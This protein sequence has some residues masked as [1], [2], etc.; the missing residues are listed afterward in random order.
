MANIDNAANTYLDSLARHRALFD[1]MEQYQPQVS[2]LLSA[3][4]QTLAAGGKVIWFGNG[5]SAADAQHL[6]AEFVVRYKKERGPLASI[7]LTTDTSILTAHSNDYHFDTVFERQVQ[8]LCKPQDLVIG[9]TT[10]GTSAN[11]NLALQAAND[12]GAYTV[13]LTGR[14]GGT[15]KD[16]AKLPIII[17]ND[18][19]ARIQE[20]HM[21]IGHWLCEALDMLV[22][23]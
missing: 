8:A 12:I 11:I 21:F 16:I 5:G 18:E 19:T 9:L 2:Q 17:S 1:T 4:H 6:A 3:C 22:A 23:E 13:A 14:E 10:S 15:V 20:A 7:A